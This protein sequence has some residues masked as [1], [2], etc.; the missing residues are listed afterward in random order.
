MFSLPP[1]SQSAASGTDPATPSAASQLAG[2]E[3]SFFSQPAASAAA[4]VLSRDSILALYGQAGGTAAGP[5]SSRVG[6]T[7]FRARTVAIFP[8]VV[9]EHSSAV[10]CLS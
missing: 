2:E 8:S 1:V 6:L 4:G 7:G 10:V 3:A 9:Y 5:Y